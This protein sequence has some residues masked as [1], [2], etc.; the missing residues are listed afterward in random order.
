MHI[1]SLVA[2]DAFLHQSY[3]LNVRYGELLEA[4]IWLAQSCELNEAGRMAAMNWATILFHQ[5]FLGC[6]AGMIRVIIFFVLLSF[7]SPLPQLQ[8]W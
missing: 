5:P 3:K 6:F 8:A 2:W 7:F 1:P 4:C